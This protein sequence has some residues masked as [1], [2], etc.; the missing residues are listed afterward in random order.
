MTIKPRAKQDEL[1]RL[2]KCRIRGLNVHVLRAIFWFINSEQGVAFAAFHHYVAKSGRSERTVQRTVQ[3]A[4]DY[5]VLRRE[6]RA[7]PPAIWSPVLM[8]MEPD[9]AVRRA[10]AMAGRY[11]QEKLAT[12]PSECPPPPLSGGPA[13]VPEF[14]VP[15][16]GGLRPEVIDALAASGATPEIIAAGVAVASKLAPNLAPS[17]TPKL[18]PEVA[19]LNPRRKNQDLKTGL[20]PSP[21]PRDAPRRDALPPATSIAHDLAVEIG[22]HCGLGPRTYAW[23][24]HWR[25]D[26][27]RII[28]RWLTEFGWDIDH[29]R[30]V[31]QRV[32]ADKRDGAPESVRY[33]EK[34]IGRLYARLAQLRD[35]IEGKGS[36]G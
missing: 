10:D 33:F 21:P 6:Y 15:V 18:A 34:P 36:T 28:Q 5:G 12:P 27:P 9:E 1:D 25:R 32:M 13:S 7:G 20:L 23:P 31:V 3:V 2:A 24:E 29:I 35:E 30:S 22:L 19:P 17:P 26:A 11:R 8:D 14:D 16:F 4:C